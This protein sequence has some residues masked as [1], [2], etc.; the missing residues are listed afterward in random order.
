MNELIEGWN[1]YDSSGGSGGCEGLIS[2]DGPM[3]NLA[4]MDEVDEEVEG[5]IE[6]LDIELVT[7]VEEV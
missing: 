2:R 1:E 5:F 7:L 4:M 6:V 3:I